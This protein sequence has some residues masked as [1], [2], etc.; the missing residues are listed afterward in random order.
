LSA[1]AYRARDRFTTAVRHRSEA[2]L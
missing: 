1:G 2:L